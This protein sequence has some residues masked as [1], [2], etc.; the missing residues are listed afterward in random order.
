MGARNEFGSTI[1]PTNLLTVSQLV[2]EQKKLLG[3]GGLCR[4]PL[5]LTFHMVSELHPQCG[6]MAPRARCKHRAE[7][8]NQC[9]A[10]PGELY[11]D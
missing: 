9:C 5:T 11:N 4:A 6:W 2:C 8:R 3:F 7:G 10:T 1:S